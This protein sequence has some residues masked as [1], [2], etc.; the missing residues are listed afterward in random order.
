MYPGQG[1]G[2]SSPVQHAHAMLASTSGV[3]SYQ[4]HG[5]TSYGHRRESK[6][7][8]M[9]ARSQSTPSMPVGKTP[10]SMSM[11]YRQDTGGGGMIIAMG[12]TPGPI[13]SRPQQQQAVM[14]TPF[15]MLSN[16][17]GG[18]SSSSAI[19]TQSACALWGEVES[20]KHVVAHKQPMRPLW[21]EGWKASSIM[22]SVPRLYQAPP[23]LPTASIGEATT[24]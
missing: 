6:R 9:V 2:R 17:T 16:T 7:E 24:R 1:P 12:A 23:S 18:S 15:Q 21:Q 22:C 14:S 3:R 8:A 19:E 5:Y 10:S 4:S 11:T 13:P 20:G